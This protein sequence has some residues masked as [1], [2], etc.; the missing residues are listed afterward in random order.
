MAGGEAMSEIT[1]HYCELPARW[2][3]DWIADCDSL[4]C[5]APLCNAHRRVMDRNVDHC[6]TEHTPEGPG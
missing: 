1:C 2:R 3:C 4:P 6:L 5:S